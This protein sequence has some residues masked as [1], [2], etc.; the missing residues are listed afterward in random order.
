MYV[1][2]AAT[3]QLGRLVVRHLLDRV[4]ADRVAVVVRDPAK[5]ADLADRGVAIRTAD[6]DDAES[7]VGV[8]GPGDR[9][10]LV[11]GNEFGI[12]VAQHAAVVD[13]AKAAGVALLAYTGILG[14]PN[15]RF[16]VADDHHVTERLIQDSGVPYTFLRNG[17]YTE[18]Y[19]ARLPGVP[20][21]GTILGSAAPD[22]RL[23]TAARTDYAEAAAIVL[24]GPGHE[25]ATYELAGDTAWTLAEYAD[26][27]TRLSGTPVAYRALPAAEYARALRAA[28]LPEP[29]IPVFADTEAAIAR[30]ELA[31]TT[32]HLAD[33]LGR[34]TTP[35]ADSV[36]AALNP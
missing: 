10:L 26:V 2:T 8:F 14:G 1:V 6:H 23:A 34:P 22:S 36:T 18:N 35:L 32:G 17:W 12:R 33:L 27:V 11:S 9:V 13:A 15:T 30:G 21:G 28:G 5:A 29:M 25:Y 16:L 31:T 20:A 24:T 7:L 4:P 3:G 19:T